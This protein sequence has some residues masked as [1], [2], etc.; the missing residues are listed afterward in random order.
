MLA[1]VAEKDAKQ[2]VAEQEEPVGIAAEQAGQ[3][4]NSR[5]EAAV[6]E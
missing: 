1:K 5:K 4:V 6:A 3:V 2:L